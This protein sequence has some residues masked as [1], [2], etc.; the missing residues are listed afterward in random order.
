MFRLASIS[1]I[2]PWSQVL[3]GSDA[4]ISRTYFWWF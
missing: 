1:I 4:L 3:I 2:N